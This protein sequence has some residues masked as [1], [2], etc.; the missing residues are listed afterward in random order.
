MTLRPLGVLHLAAPAKHGG[1]ERV[2]IELGRAQT[3]R[4]H[5]VTVALVLVPADERDHPVALALEDAGVQTRVLTLG[6]RAYLAERRRVAELIEELRPDVLHTHGFRPDVVDA[7]VGRGHG[8]ATVTTAHG[9]IG[10]TA[11]GRLYEHLQVRAGRR[12][13]AVIAVSERVADR[14]RE[15]GVGPE[16]L[17][18]VPNAI[19]A[20]Q[21]LP[22]SEARAA[23]GVDDAPFVVGWVG[24]VSREKGADV[25]IEALGVAPEAVSGVIV[26][27][28]PERAAVEERAGALGLG[29]RFTCVGAVPEASRYLS[30]FDAF[31]L[32]S[33]TEGTPMAL[34]EAMSAG[35]PVVATAVGGVPAVLDGGVGL[36]VPPERPEAIAEAFTRIQGDDALREALSRDGRHR[37]ETAFGIDPWVDTHARIYREALTRRRAKG[38]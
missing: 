8:L 38:V 11:R 14:Y 29:D 23:L 31:A 3:A 4:G 37:V 35:V 9:F 27:D 7:G 21:L 20:V 18:L 13:D 33:R 2:L 26:G 34:L 24:R 30:A 17:H 1:L 10:D 36:L 6:A 28:G 12:M 5:A 15:G 32:T 25:F 22:R 16:R 19:G